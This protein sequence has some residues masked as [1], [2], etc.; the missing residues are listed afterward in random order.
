MIFYI[1]SN[2]HIFFPK[3]QLK[4]S[5]LGCY[6][7]LALY[8]KRQSGQCNVTAYFYWKLKL[9]IVGNGEKPLGQ[10]N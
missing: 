2:L 8:L 9:K 10:R 1:L 4:P 6:P 3:V 5:N 7:A